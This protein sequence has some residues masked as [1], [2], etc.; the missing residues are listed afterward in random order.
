MQD[1][2]K[3][4][5]NG[6]N[7][8]AS[9]D[10]CPFCPSGDRT[11]SGAETMVDSSA[12]DRDK[13]VI[14]IGKPRMSGASRGAE[15]VNRDA[16]MI[17]PAPGKGS[18]AVAD[19]GAGLRKLVGWLVTFDI[20]PVGQDYKIH[21]GRHIIGSRNTCDIMIQQAGVSGEHAILLYRNEKLILQDN[22]S[23]NGTFV[24]DEM[25]EDKIELQNDDVIKVGS[26]NLKVKLI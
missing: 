16:T 13:T 11:I 20:N 5:K 24:N 22:L 23:T 4:C 15:V 21:V 6:H 10:S 17:Y 19:A 26:V 3:T 18:D 7:Y 2:F 9:L 1:K 14:D 8:D 12:H 25:I